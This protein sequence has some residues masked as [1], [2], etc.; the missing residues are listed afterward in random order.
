[1]IPTLR[2]TRCVDKPLRR[3]MKYVLRTPANDTRC[4]P[5]CECVVCAHNVDPVAS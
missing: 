5:L 4:G 3:S 2:Y 1:M